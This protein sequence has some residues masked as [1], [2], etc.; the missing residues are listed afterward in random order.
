MS[1]RTPSTAGSTP[2]ASTGTPPNQGSG[3]STDASG[4]KQ[5][6]VDDLKAEIERL[7]A[8]QAK[9]AGIDPEAA[10]AALA[11]AEAAEEK[12]STGDPKA[13]I[14]GET[15][16]FVVAPGRSIVT[17]RGPAGPGDK[18]ALNR[19][20]GEKLRK[21]GF[22]L[23]ENGDIIANTGGPAVSKGAEITER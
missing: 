7:K 12:M 6:E 13:E 2:A 10:K 23:D 14:S 3:A 22:F 8:E 19:D 21:L 16:E 18:V 9:F 15:A 11:R 1:N 5:A 20:E 4:A 17:D